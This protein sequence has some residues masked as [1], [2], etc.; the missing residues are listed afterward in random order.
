MRGVPYTVAVTLLAELGDLPRFEN[1]RQL[2][3]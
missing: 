2:M 3:S 1:S